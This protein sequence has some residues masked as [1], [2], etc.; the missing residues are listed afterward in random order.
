MSVR[1]SV[2]GPDQLPPPGCPGFEIN[3]DL[4]ALACIVLKQQILAFGGFLELTLANEVNL[5]V[6]LKSC[7]LCVAQVVIGNTFPAHGRLMVQ[8]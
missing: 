6:V 7:A 4:Q 3:L 8:N 2:T 5:G 1:V